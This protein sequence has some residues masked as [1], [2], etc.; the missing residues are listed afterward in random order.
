MQGGILPAP[1]V[2]DASPSGD[3]A[4]PCPPAQASAQLSQG[5]PRFRSA[6][7]SP[8]PA[9]QVEASAGPRPEQ[10]PI[11]PYENPQNEESSSPFA[12]LARRCKRT[13]TSSVS[14]R[15]GA[16]VGAVAG[17]AVLAGAG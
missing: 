14:G 9:L 3:P 12:N 15:R 7:P 13:L 5:N 16:L 4:V 6:G 1:S 8:S 17:F 11:V 2:H 10:R